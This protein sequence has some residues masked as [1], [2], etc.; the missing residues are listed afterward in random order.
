MRQIAGIVM[1]DR[2]A[3]FFANLLH[4]G[5]YRRPTWCIEL[6]L[7]PHAEKLFGENTGIFYLMVALSAFPLIEERYDQMKIPRTMAEKLGLW[8]GGGM[9]I[10][11]AG[12][13]GLPG[14]CSIQ[15][16]WLRHAIDGRLFRIG[17]L[18]YLLH[19]YPEWVPAVYRNRNNGR[20]CLLSR[21]GISYTKSGQRPGPDDTDPAEL[22]M[23]HLELE[24]DRIA[25]YRILPDGYADVSKMTVLDLHE[26]EPAATAWEMVPSIH[27]PAGE[28]LSEDAIRN[29][30]REAVEFFREYL[31]QEIRMFVSCSWLFFYEWQKE[32]PDSNI[33]AFAREGYLFPAFP[34]NRTS[35]LFF[36]FGR[37]DRD[38]RN[39]PKQTSLERAFHK[40]LESGR[41]LGEC[42]WAY[43]CADIELYG[44]QKYRREVL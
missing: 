42:G 29:S 8:I 21:A 7:L 11:A 41:Y 34:L 1:H 30:L 26:W 5:F 15:L 37:S 38:I 10:Y 3:A 19:E 28:S 14:F 16:H 43:L 35:G 33:A 32:L 44:T 20:V 9:D 2:A 31:H 23:S 17:R 4:Y 36:L 39:L 27:I 25:G 18:E 6:N 24:K 13:D 40:I 22:I 12:H